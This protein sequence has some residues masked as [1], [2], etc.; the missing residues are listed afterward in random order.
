MSIESGISR[1]SLKTSKIYFDFNLNRFNSSN[2]MDKGR[3]I[4]FCQ[5]CLSSDTRIRVTG[6]H[7]KKIICNIMDEKKI[8]TKL[9][10]TSQ[11]QLSYEKLRADFYF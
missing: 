3:K 2:M 1:N 4:L 6:S 5:F 11:F 9:S 10:A 8:C 7:K